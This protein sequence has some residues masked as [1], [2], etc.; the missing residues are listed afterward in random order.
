[1]P[2]FYLINFDINICFHICYLMTYAHCLCKIEIIISWFIEGEHDRDIMP[3]F[4]C[5]CRTFLYALQTNLSQ[6]Q[7]FII[8]RSPAGSTDRAY[9]LPKRGPA[10]TSGK[11]PRASSTIQGQAVLSKGKQSISKGGQRLLMI[12][13]KS[14]T[15]WGFFSSLRWVKSS[16]LIQNKQQI[17]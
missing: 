7:Q 14:N 8:K 6:I 16:P 3:L 4:F 5:A 9:F 15:F 1:M 12:D 17:V 10:T 11:S 2:I 13:Y